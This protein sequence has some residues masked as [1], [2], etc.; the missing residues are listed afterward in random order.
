[1]P[2]CQLS[3]FSNDDR[4]RAS[5]APTVSVVV[6]SYNH[7]DFI[8]DCLNSISEQSYQPIEVV[9]IDDCSTDNT[10]RL[11]NSFLKQ[12]KHR[13]TNTVCIRNATN[14]G[15]H[16]TLNRGLALSSGDIVSFINSDDKYTPDRIE[17]MV[18]A[19][20]KTGSEFAFSGVATI[21]ERGEPVWHEALCHHI[22]YRPRVACVRLP[23]I[24][25]G[26]LW[27]QLTASTGNILV[28]RSL[29]CKVGGFS[30]L[31]YCHDWDYVLR[32]AFFS[33][34]LF[35]DEALYEYR[36]HGKNSF[37]SLTSYAKADTRVV[38]SNYFRTVMS[39]APQNP[40]A[41]APQNWPGLFRHLVRE[42]GMEQHLIDIYN[43][44]R[45]HHRTVTH[46][47]TCNVA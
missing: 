45:A 20:L 27:R 18:G 3:D 15:A 43:P 41:P 5:A 10:Y 31:K 6:P 4:P 30:S 42:I 35:V 14:R 13:F 40:K 25:W 38:V 32:C 44:Y 21:G 26:L 29:A 7:E 36:V 34:P 2:D 22:A 28:S 47:I 39:S 46:P 23:S 11:A 33:E 9:L 8:L 24:S 12:G 17:K 37:R 19:M 1:M 16:A